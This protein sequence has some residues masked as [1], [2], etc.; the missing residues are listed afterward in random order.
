MI[1]STGSNT[2]F[3]PIHV[4]QVKALWSKFQSE[5]KEGSPPAV[6]ASTAAIAASLQV[7][8]KTKPQLSYRVCES[9]SPTPDDGVAADQAHAPDSF[10][11]GGGR[12]E[13]AEQQ[14]QEQEN[15]L[16]SNSREHEG[17]E[18]PRPRGVAASCPPS[19]AGEE[20]Q[21]AEASTNPATNLLRHPLAYVPPKITVIVDTIAPVAGLGSLV[22]SLSAGADK[23]GESK[24]EAS[25]TARVDTL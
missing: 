2:P 7:S 22:S 5:V 25:P 17:G 21:Q 6:S 13:T 23:R 24:A 11:A 12:S 8:Q 20:K 9:P 4:C 15:H 3:A 14:K 10:S 16:G 19:T 18:K 1:F